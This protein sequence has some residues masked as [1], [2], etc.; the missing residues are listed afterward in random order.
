MS[1]LLAHLSKLLPIISVGSGMGIEE[2]FLSDH[3]YTVTCI[4]PAIRKR[5]PWLTDK[6]LVREPDYP[7][8]PAYLRAHP[9]YNGEVQVLLQYPLPDYG[10]YDITT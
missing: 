8:V 9:E 6:V 5:D 4:D 1:H 7:S 10:L 3:G 2:Q